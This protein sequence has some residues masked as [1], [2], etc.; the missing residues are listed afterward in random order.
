MKK[1]LALCMCLL[2]LVGCSDAS[3]SVSNGNSAIVTVGGKKVTKQQLYEVLRD[4]DNGDTV[5][6][7][8]TNYIVNK[9]VTLTSEMEAAAQA[10]LQSTLDQ[11]GENLQDFLDYYGYASTDVYYEKE[12][13]PSV[14][15]EYLPDAYIEEN[16]DSV[17]EYYYPTMVRILETETAE[18]ANNAKKEIQAGATFKEVADKYSTKSET[19]YDGNEYTVSRADSETLATNVVTVIREATGPTLSAVINNDAADRF[20]IVQ[21]TECNPNQYKD[22]AIAIVK[23]SAD[24]ETEMMAYYCK[25]YDFKIYDIDLYNIFEEY[26]PTYLQQ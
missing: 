7:L 20:Y 9:E 17:M 1:I 23:E 13:L 3:A 4:Q 18:E 14:M 26:Y 2:L 25:K 11:L 10:E 8:L 12:V 24:L 15:Y 16:W 19:L 21:I 6:T 5:L 22:E